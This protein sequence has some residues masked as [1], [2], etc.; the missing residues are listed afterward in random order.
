MTD[1][2]ASAAGEDLPDDLRARL[3]ALIR[4]VAPG[5]APRGV[6]RVLK[7]TDGGDGLVTPEKLARASFLDIAPPSSQKKSRR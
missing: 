7:A 6:P 3:K 1:A 5:A 4:P 2:A